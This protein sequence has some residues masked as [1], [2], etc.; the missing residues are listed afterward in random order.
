MQRSLYVPSPGVFAVKIQV[1]L[2]RT[3]RKAM[4]PHPYA[5]LYRT[6]RYATVRPIITSLP[7]I[8]GNRHTIGDREVELSA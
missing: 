2:T 7:V 4:G 1:H 6:D 8:H 5:P 3:P